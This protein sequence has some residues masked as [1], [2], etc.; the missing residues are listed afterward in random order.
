MSEFE[1]SP[2]I[3]GNV[4]DQFEPNEVIEL[5]VDQ[6]AGAQTRRSE[7]MRLD[8]FL[9]NS[10]DGLSR[11]RIQQLI[12]E[13]LILVN[14]GN[15]KANLRLRGGEFVS[16]QIPPPVQLDVQPENIP[17]SIVFE[18]DSTVV[19]NKPA[20]MTTH[21]G[22]G[23]ISGTLVNALLFHCKG[24]LSGISGTLRPGIVH[25]L[26]K[27]TTGLIVVAKS[28]LAHQSLAMQI[29]ERQVGRIYQALVEGVIADDSGCISKPIGRHPVRRKEMAVV[30]N[31][32]SA[33]SDFIVIKR[34]SKFTLVQVKLKTGRTHQ[35]R[36]HMASIGFPVAGDLVYNNKQSGTESWRKKHGLLGQAL[37]AFRLTFK[38]PKTDKPL[39][40]EAELPED[41]QKLLSNLT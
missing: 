4:E 38:H 26:D 25:R 40:F 29:R 20:G 39:A 19:V 16:I 23:V 41:F 24:T 11:S 35:I 34:F 33:Q 14:G 8:Q 1:S 27:D 3:E 32:R 17:L 30:E 37:H 15:A 21:P 2:E 18:D 9:F 31:G 22:A 5:V 36:V 28:D 13:G 6:Y 10:L 12:E 7:R